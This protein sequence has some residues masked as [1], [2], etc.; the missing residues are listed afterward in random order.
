[1]SH[2]PH[3][4]HAEFPEHK[5]ILHR[6][7]MEDRHYQS[8]AEQYHDLNREIHRIESGIEST[9]DERL[10]ALKKMRL[11]MLDDVAEMIQREKV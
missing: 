7:K 11:S 10:E 4:L 6:L 2:T 9:S 8:L 3:D 5:E 1:M